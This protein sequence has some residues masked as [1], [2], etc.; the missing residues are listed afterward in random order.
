MTDPTTGIQVAPTEAEMSQVQD[1]LRRAIN[2]IVGMSQLQADVDM[3]RS[4]VTALQADTEKLRQQNA[5]LD[6]ALYQSRQARNDLTTRLAQAENE[7]ADYQNR[8]VHLNNDLE[9]VQ[10]ENERLSSQ[11]KEANQARDNAELRVMELEDELKAANAKLASIR[12]GYASIFG[13]ATK[14]VEAPKPE[15]SMTLSEPKPEPTLYTDPEPSPIGSTRR[16]LGDRW[17]P[18]ALWDEQRSEYYVEASPQ[19]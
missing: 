2:A 18:G 6:E 9:N 15:P 19:F 4:T 17:E 11:L 14:P 3:L 1:I 16:Y 7:R 10:S 8:Y 5:G 13:E 12:E